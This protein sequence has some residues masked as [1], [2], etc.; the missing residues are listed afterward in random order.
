MNKLVQHYPVH[1]GPAN[2]I[3]F[4]PSGNFLLSA[5]DDSTLRLYDLLEGRLIYTLRGHDGAVTACSFSV[6]GANFAS[7][8]AD[9]QVFLWRTNFDQGA[10]GA[11]QAETME[12]GEPAQPRKQQQDGSRPSRQSGH[13][14]QPLAGQ[15]SAELASSSRLVTDVGRHGG[16][17]PSSAFDDSLPRPSLAAPVNGGGVAAVGSSTEQQQQPG[18]V[19]PVIA[20]TLE[21]VV[22]Q[23]DIL[24]QTVSILEQR[25]TL[26]ENK[27]KDVLDSQRPP[28][29]K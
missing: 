26:T 1:E 12:V 5:G 27:L 8:G 4:H 20:N 16:R 17:G 9:Q 22:R 13:Q 18:S 2:G 29:A 28:S 15:R 7:G 14:Q 10:G 24:T 3:A 25:L 21:H 6:C 11:P 23:L 19:P